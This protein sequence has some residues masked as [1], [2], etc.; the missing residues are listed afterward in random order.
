MGRSTAE[1]L[2]ENA[3]AAHRQGAIE[4]A[5]AL[6]REVLRV[7]PHNAAA[8]GNLAIIAARQ[9]DLAGAESLLRSEIAHW[10]TPPAYNNLGLVLQQQ[11][12]FADAIAAHRHALEL[13]PGYAE[14]FLALGNALKEQRDV[15]GAMQAYRSAVAARP[16]YAE[17][18]NNIGVLLQM[19]G[20]FE[21]AASAYRAAVA[22]Q[23]AYLEAQF[24]LGA[25]LHD[26][27][28]LEAAENAYRRL[29]AA[30]PAV[31]VAHNNL[32][33]VLR[34]RGL[35][36]QALAAFD[37]A[38]GLQPDYAE[39]LHN[40]AVVL[41]QQARLEESL[42]SYGRALM[43]RPDYLDAANNAGIV[44]QELG[45]ARDAINLYR[46]MVRPTAAHA[47]SYNNLGTALLADGSVDEAKA[48]F[49]QALALRPAFPE[50]A[51]NLGNALREQGHLDQAIA[52]WRDAF[53][54]RPGYPDAV[55]QL[56]FHRAL[57][58][59]WADHAAD[60]DSLLQLVRGGV[61]IPP[62]YLFPTQAAPSDQLRCA[63]QWIGPTLPKEA[64]FTHRPPD[65]DRRIRLGYLSGDFHQHAT[66]HLI[67]ELFEHHDRTRFEVFGYG[68]GPDDASP[69]RDRIAHAFDRF[70]DVR[71]FSHR[72]A[73]GQIHADQIDILIDLKGYTH[74][75]RP[76]IAALRPSPIQ[77][78]YL[79]Y[80]AT[81][82]ADFIDYVLVDR[83][84]VPESQQ[85]FFPERLAQLPGCYQV[86]DRERAIAAHETA[87]QDWGLP[88][89]GLVLCCFNNSYKLSPALFDIW[90]RVLKSAPHSVLW[91]LAPNQ[92]VRDNLQGE[93]T[94]RGVDPQ[95]LVFAPTVPSAEHLERHRHA[96]LFLDTWPCNAHTTASDALWCG[97]PVLTLTGETFASRVAGSL[98]TASGLPELVMASL[99]EYENTALQLASDPSRLDALRK[100]LLATR[101][102]NPVF[103]L[104]RTAGHI[105]AAY[106]RMW[107][108]W[109]DGKKPVA[110]AIE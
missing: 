110:F 80:P 41:Q 23:P 58:C 22:A 2:L 27:H 91:L 103:D 95:R 6:Y 18:H 14:A 3:L 94:R 83:F 7:D 43:L 40:R 13:N 25:V 89:E 5:K 28:D 54:L 57:V 73:A 67:A 32:G 93:A 71:A 101:D 97:L 106:L 88:A 61:R 37:T 104:A 79:G 105:E 62:F 17:A 60:Q 75:A 85:A 38:I 4:E 16:S 102:S 36:D 68:Y 90:M 74:D 99:A 34:D 63:Q 82:G 31:A 15:D 10:S 26:M 64:A 109:R 1:T 92:W 77:V 66:A 39:A 47:D 76:A 56:V 46:R 72:D 24:N 65:Q 50:A 108:N 49:E 59:D 78:S 30:N 81:M 11:G 8:N 9:G 29:I 86:N 55:A 84:V 44:L 53:R 52:A 96:D 51:Y 33:A 107:Q 69:M 21:E 100:R 19:Q 42:D 70:V 87:R 20:R 45:R 48:A 98:L 12:R 35:P